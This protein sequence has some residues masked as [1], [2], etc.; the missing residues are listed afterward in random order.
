MPDSAVVVPVARP[1][2]ERELCGKSAHG[3]AD[4]AATFLS[5][6]GMHLGQHRCGYESAHEQ[7]FTLS[8]APAAAPADDL[9]SKLKQHGEPRAS[10]V[11]SE[12][13]FAAVKAQLLG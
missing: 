3:H 8:P 11:L 9:V 7:C 1:R 4:V 5:E 12:A 13:E 6:P 10:G 2:P